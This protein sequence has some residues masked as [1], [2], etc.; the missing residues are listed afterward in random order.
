MTKEQIVEINVNLKNNKITIIDYK[1]FFEDTNCRFSLDVIN[2]LQELRRIL[3]KVLIDD[4]F[5]KVYVS[6]YYDKLEDIYKNKFWYSDIIT[7]DTN[8]TV[9]EIENYFVDCGFEPS[10][11]IIQEEPVHLVTID[12]KNNIYKRQCKNLIGVYWD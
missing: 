6:I 5:A 11:I 1:A 12:G 7:L 2:E 8:I 4:R 3:T 10:D 9:N